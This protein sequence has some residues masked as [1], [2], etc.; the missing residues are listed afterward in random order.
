MKYIYIKKRHFYRRLSKYLHNKIKLK[1]KKWNDNKL[2]YIL[3]K[4]SQF[5][6]FWILKHWKCNICTFENLIS[7]NFKNVL[8]RINGV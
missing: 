2:L 1:V 5:Q 4:H 7:Q 3:K 6:I 8:L